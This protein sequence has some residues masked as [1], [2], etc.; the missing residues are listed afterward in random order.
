MDWYLKRWGIEMSRFDL[1]GEVGVV[2]GG[3][4]QWHHGQISPAHVRLRCGLSDVLPTSTVLS[5]R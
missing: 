4:G 3:T 2:I 5:S 1:S